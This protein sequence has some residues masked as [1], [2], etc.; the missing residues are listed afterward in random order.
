MIDL[1]ASAS[2]A[3]RRALPRR[4]RTLGTLILCTPI[5]GTLCLGSLVASA[6]TSTVLAQS[7]TTSESP[8]ATPGAEPKL[9]TQGIA[10]E[11]PVATSAAAA[12]TTASE[13]DATV[14]VSSTSAESA[15]SEE[16]VSSRHQ[17]WLFEVAPLITAPERALFATLKKTYQRDAFIQQFWK[18]RDPFPKTSRNELKER[19]PVRVAEAKSRYGSLTDDRARIYLVHGPAAGGFEVKCTKKH[20][21]AEVWVY[22]GSDTVDQP[23]ALV[24]YRPRLSA[25]AKLWNPS[26]GVLGLQQFLGRVRGCINGSRLQQ[27]VAV[28]NS[29]YDSYVS[30]LRRYLVKPRPRSQEWIH[31]FVAFSTDLPPGAETLE[32]A[33]EF[34]YL[35]RNQHR[36]VVQGLL[37]IPVEQASV[38]EYAGY[39]SHDFLLTGEVI[40]DDTLFE[41]FRYKFGT[42]EM[43]AQGTIPLAFQRFLRPGDYRMILKLE[44]LNSKRVL[45]QAHQLSIPQVDELY[46]LPTFQDPRTEQLFAEATEAI[47][48]GETSLRLIPPQGGLQTGFVRFDTLVSGSEVEKIRFYLDDKFVLAKNRPP[49]SV[50]MDL[51]SYPDLHTLRAEGL[52][53]NGEEVASD[54]LL[55]NSGGYRFDVNLIEPRKG[56]RYANSLRARAEV[57]IPEGRSL[58]RVELYLNETLVSTLYQE[59]YVHPIILP[60]NEEVAYVRAVAYLPDGNS[61]EDLVFINAP[62]YLEELE[63]QF[64]ELYTTVLDKQGRP[65]DGLGKERFRVEEDGVRQ[66]IARF[67]KVLDLPIHVGI[68]IDNSASMVGTLGEVRKAA[69]SFFQQA[70][71]PKDRAAVITFNSFPHLAVELTNDRSALGS[72]LAGLVP[73]GQ[74]AL[75]DSVMFALYYFTGIK[76]QRAILVLSDGRDESSRFE[77]SET[78]EYARR[79]GITIYSIGFRLNDFSA[80]QKLTRLAD[81]T[82]GRSFHIHDIT[83]L[84]PIYSQIQQELRSQYLIAYQS[85]N[86]S[87]EEDFRA[88]DLTIDDKSLVVKTLSGYYP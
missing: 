73:E 28:I 87:E 67:E 43:A 75:Y 21:A 2:P 16:P 18:V 62:D 9:D 31:T 66:A 80:R 83:E 48:A 7:S 60:A 51:G 23:A 3:S 24:F 42:P 59:P 77:F 88:V 11:A 39:R 14:G 74:T 49:Y 37:S 68:L 1:P 34:A 82:G 70:I 30:T 29:N 45:R 26:S 84:E 61:T 35:G 15:P 47:E 27:L 56:K 72:G 25:D 38:G 85:T 64:V 6:I 69:L 57:T 12:P 22:Q 46:E 44:D 10:T 65:V 20:I 63:I 78:L 41:S 50:E 71:K 58:E 53:A 13:G 81:E 52:D 17:N 19:W 4:A 5:L 76:G 32:G 79:A 36:T 54:E 86:T 33:V 55:I 40:R 8:V